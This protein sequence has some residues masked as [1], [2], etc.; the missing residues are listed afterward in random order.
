MLHYVLVLLCIPVLLLWAQPL[1]PDVSCSSQQLNY[2]V[3]CVLPPELGVTAIALM[4][5]VEFQETCK[6]FMV[7]LNNSGRLTSKYTGQRRAAY[8]VWPGP[9]PPQGNA[10]EHVIFL[11]DDE[12][13]LRHIINTRLPYPDL[14]IISR[15]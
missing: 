1:V 9:W 6:Y 12:V 15:R 14:R 11:S 7:S 8:D 13:T 10:L 2:G 5:E 3:R 4:V